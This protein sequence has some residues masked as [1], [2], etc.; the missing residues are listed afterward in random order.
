M[1]ETVEGEIRAMEAAAR[2]AD[3]RYHELIRNDPRFGIGG[4]QGPALSDPPASP[5]RPGPSGVIEAYRYVTGMPQ[6]EPGGR[7]PSASGTIAY[8]DLDGTP[9]IGVNSNAPGYTSG[10]ETLARVLRS[11]LIDEF[12]RRDVVNENSGGSIPTTPYFTPKPMHCCGPRRCMVV[13]SRA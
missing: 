1:T 9:I 3:A 5:S 12:S 13:R 4:N 7:A 10:D 11:E 2:E 8:I 6:V